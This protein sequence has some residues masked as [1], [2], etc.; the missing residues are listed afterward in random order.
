MIKKRGEE[1]TLRKLK[2]DRT[3]DQWLFSE[4]LRK[5]GHDKFE[6]ILIMY[7]E[8]WL[9]YRLICEQLYEAIP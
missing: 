6:R 5:I 2:Y 8:Q 1:R 7:N 9:T 3:D 4:I